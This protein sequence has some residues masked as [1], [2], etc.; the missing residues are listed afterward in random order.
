MCTHFKSYITR[1]QYLVF[2]NEIQGN[3]CKIGSLW[4]LMLSA[5]DIYNLLEALTP[6][7]TMKRAKHGR[8]TMYFISGGIVELYSGTRVSSD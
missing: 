3:L 7:F 8:V 5:S 6:S 4:Y 1:F 2:G